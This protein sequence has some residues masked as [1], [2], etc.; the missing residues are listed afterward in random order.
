MSQVY[1]GSDNKN[2]M[3]RKA[4]ISFMSQVYHGSDNI[5]VY[6]HVTYSGSIIYVTGLS[7]V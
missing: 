2:I 7:R 3:S 6:H 5:H 4:G 1:H